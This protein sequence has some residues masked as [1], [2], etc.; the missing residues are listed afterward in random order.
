MNLHKISIR[1]HALVVLFGLSCAQMPLCGMEIAEISLEEGL[2][3]G[4][5]EGT[6]EAGFKVAE[7]GVE[8]VMEEM[9]VDVNTLKA[10]DPILESKM[11]AQIEAKLESAVEGV[12]TQ[13]AAGSPPQLDVKFSTGAQEAVDSVKFAEVS[14]ESAKALSGAVPEGELTVAQ[15]SAAAAEVAPLNESMA[16]VSSNAG[17]YSE[18]VKESILPC[19]S[20]A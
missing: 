2:E 18:A 16:E 10:E 15:P 8:T 14:P 1:W 6:E 20:F 5:L 9:G 19:C 7:G 13:I 17:D 3:K 12:N 11:E 4:L